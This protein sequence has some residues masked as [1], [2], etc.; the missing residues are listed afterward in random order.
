MKKWLLGLALVLLPLVAAAERLE[1]QVVD[2]DQQFLP[3]ESTHK[4]CYGDSVA[5][6]Y[7]TK[8][9][10]CF[11]RGLADSFSYLVPTVEPAWLNVQFEEETNAL[12]AWF[13]FKEF[14]PGA[15]TFASPS[16][17]WGDW[18]PVYL[19]GEYRTVSFK[20]GLWD[21]CAVRVI[22][23]AGGVSNFYWFVEG[24]RD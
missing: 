15:T 13:S 4:M 9:P 14:T 8:G 5:Y 2:T 23:S 24:Y 22:G 17:T 1:I 11:T 3:I 20:C 10:A 18:V 19:G 7:T 16:Y 21:S 6:Y 12:T